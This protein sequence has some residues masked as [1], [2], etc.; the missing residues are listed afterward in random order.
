VEIKASS[1]PVPFAGTPDQEAK[2]ARRAKTGDGKFVEIGA[3]GGSVIRVPVS[4]GAAFVADIVLS[5]ARGSS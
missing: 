3:A 2:A 1:L 4:V 5:L